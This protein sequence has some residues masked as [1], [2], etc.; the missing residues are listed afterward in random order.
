ME[1]REENP[2]ELL[3]QKLSELEKVWTDMKTGKLSSAVSCI[4]VE[5]ALELMENSPRKLMISLQHDQAGPEAELRSPYRRK[6]FHDS[7]DNDDETRVTTFSLSTC[8]SSNVMRVGYNNKYNNEKQDKKKK[9]GSIVCVC[10][11]G[12]L[13][14]VLVVLI[15]GFDNRQINTLVPT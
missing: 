15:N 1:E 7:E 8:W 5:E 6:L 12:L 10:M 9:R 2:H 13:L 14:W 3:K 4:T 11:I